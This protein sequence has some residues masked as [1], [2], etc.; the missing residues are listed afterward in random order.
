M[1][2]SGHVTIFA[3]RYVEDFNK[4]SGISDPINVAYRLRVAYEDEHTFSGKFESLLQDPKAADLEGLVI[5]A[6]TGDMH[7]YD[8]AR[9]VRDLANAKDRLPNLKALFIGDIMS[10]E[11]EISWIEQSDMTPVLDAYPELEAFQVRGGNGLRFSSLQHEKL[12]ELVVQTG[13]LSPKTI[14]QICAAH[15]PN[16]EHLELWLGS[17]YYG[18]DATVEDVAPIISGKLFPKLTYLALA[19]SEIADDIAKALVNAPIMKQIERLDMSMG[20]MGDEG[21]EALFDALVGSSVKRL[22]VSN[23]YLSKKAVQRLFKLPIKLRARNQD[24][25]YGTPEDRYVSVAE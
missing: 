4:V 25:D 9:V 24:H 16:L 12:K 20:T 23:N 21:A 15:L 10:E 1:G 8:S 11:S 22:N 13:G 6:W 3:G 14:A 5:G 19:D 18:G 17:Q 2:I 7:D